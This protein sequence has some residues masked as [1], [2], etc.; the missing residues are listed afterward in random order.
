M[1]KISLRA[2]L[3]LGIIAMGVFTF[4]AVVEYL[5]CMPNWPS[6]C[7]TAIV[8]YSLYFGLGAAYFVSNMYESFFPFDPEAMSLTS[9][10]S[11][12]Y[13]IVASVTILITGI[14]YFVLGYLLSQLFGF[15][16][17]IIKKLFIKQKNEIL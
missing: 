14:I 10:Q 6:M 9:N 1:N 7:G 4:I 8:I 15:L 13:I 5:D 2:G 17:R 11:S 16:Y 12:E 3:V